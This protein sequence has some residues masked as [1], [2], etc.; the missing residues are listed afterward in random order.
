MSNMIPQTPYLNRIMWE[1]LEQYT[2]DMVKNQN[3][4]VYII[5]GPIF[6]QKVGAIGPNKD[7]QVPSHEFKIVVILDTKQTIHDINK[8]TPMIAVVLP[9]MDSDGNLPNLDSSTCA[10]TVSKGP[11]DKNDWAK[12]RS[13]VSEIENLSV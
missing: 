12:Y 2:R 6:A 13:T 1:H 5:A 3:K 7:I 4:K 11:Q 9:N 8:D 10:A